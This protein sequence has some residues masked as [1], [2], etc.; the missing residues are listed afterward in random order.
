M[1]LS[2]QTQQTM[3]STEIAKLTG[4]QKSNV[5]RDI[6][7]Q[8]LKGLYEIDDS[9]LNHVEIQGIAILLDNRGYVSEYHLDKEHT[10]TLISGYDVKMRHAISKRWQELEQQVA[11]PID[12]MQVLN[13]PAAMRGLL[14]TYAETVIEKDKVIA[15]QAPKVAALARL[16]ESEGSLNITEAAKA[17]GIP[18]KKMFDKLK[19]EKWIYKRAGSKNWLGY[20]DKDK[21]GYLT[22]KVQPFLL[23]DGTERISEQV[24]ITPKGLTKLAQIFSEGGAITTEGTAHA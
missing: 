24:R 21:R 23:P 15:E 20:H 14:L 3:S 12:P 7:D 4:K 13:D 19:M 10:I 11:K 18:Q 2:T 9:N 8:I 5:H 1:N 6:Q 16:S 22:H 17:L